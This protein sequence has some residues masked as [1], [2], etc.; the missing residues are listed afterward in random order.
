MTN[1]LIPFILFLSY[2]QTGDLK[3]VKNNNEIKIKIKDYYTGED[4]VGVY[5]PSKKTTKSLVLLM[6]LT[7]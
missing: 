5:D 1:L 3:N 4:L 7:F 2:F 6:N